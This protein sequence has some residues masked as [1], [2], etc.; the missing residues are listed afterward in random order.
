MCLLSKIKE[1]LGRYS[2]YLTDSGVF[3][4]RIVTQLGDGKTRYRLNAMLRL[5]DTEFDV[6]QQRRIWLTDLP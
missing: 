2:R 6:L 1:M 3:I 4:V 5:L